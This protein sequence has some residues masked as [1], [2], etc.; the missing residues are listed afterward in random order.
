MGDRVRWSSPE[1][2]HPERFNLKERH[3]TQESD[4]YALGMVTYEVLSG[5][6][7]FS[8]CTNVLLL[9][10]KILGSERPEKPPTLQ[11]EWSTTHLWGMLGRCWE[12]QPDARPSLNTVLQCLQSITRPSRLYGDQPTAAVNGSGRFSLSRPRFAFKYLCVAIGFVVPHRGGRFP[13][14]PHMYPPDVTGPTIPAA[15]APLRQDDSVGGWVG[16][17]ARNARKMFEVIARKFR[18]LWQPRRTSLD[19]V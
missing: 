8:S 1:R 2:L 3:P 10:E 11:G 4:C 14:S 5:L 17:L 19:W 6:A 18:E 12:S 13:V 16:K 9:A 15:P 7:P